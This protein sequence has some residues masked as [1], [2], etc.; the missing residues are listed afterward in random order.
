MCWP[1][2]YSSGPWFRFLIGAGRADPLVP[3]S[4]V[5]RLAAMLE[6]GGAEVTLHW[7]HAG[8]QLTPG[9]I[10]VARAWLAPAGAA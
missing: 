10:D 7:E 1:V 3:V 8:H 9:D 4:D 2:Q 6:E 5:E